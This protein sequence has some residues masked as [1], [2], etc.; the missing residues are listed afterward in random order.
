LREVWSRTLAEA[1]APATAEET[2][3]L[4]A[5]LLG[6]WE[7]PA[8]VFHG[9]GH[10]IAVLEKLD[11]LAQEASCPCLVRLAAFYHGAVLSTDLADLGRHTWGEDEARSAELALGQ[12]THLGLAEAKAAHVHDLV[13]ALGSRPKEIKSPDLAVLC[14]AER[15]ILAADP[16]TYRSYA[17]AIREECADAPL[18]L[19]LRTRITVLRR[20]LARDRL[21]LTSATA[22]W[23]SPARNNVEA[24]LARCLR[25]LSAI[26]APDGPAPSSPPVPRAPGPS[27]RRG[28]DAAAAVVRA[29]ARR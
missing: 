24:E 26:T 23:E 14:D 2:A 19:I 7:N 21:F 11:E 6:R 27:V 3:R 9:V 29:G 28:I 10:L 25:E 20:W 4:G 12:L 17:A 15:S 16:R 18:D 22:A 5:K 8:R 1:G 13:A